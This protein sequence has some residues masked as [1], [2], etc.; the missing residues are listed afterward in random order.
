MGCLAGEATLKGAVSDRLR[1]N[2]C[3]HCYS[4]RP[5]GG[6]GAADRGLVQRRHR[7]MSGRRGRTRVTGMMTH[8]SERERARAR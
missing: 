3:E 5:H 2:A 7:G 8:S 4:A 1:Q 6:G